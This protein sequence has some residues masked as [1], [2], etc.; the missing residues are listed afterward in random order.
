MSSLLVIDIH[1]LFGNLGGSGFRCSCGRHNSLA[2]RSSR[3][4]DRRRGLLLIAIANVDFSRLDQT[5]SCSLVLPT[6]QMTL[7]AW[8]ASPSSRVLV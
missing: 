3:G 5:T 4:H 1:S 6:G 2:C 7:V 8:R